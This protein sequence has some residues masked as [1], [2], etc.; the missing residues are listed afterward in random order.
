[1]ALKLITCT[2]GRT[3]T[4]PIT[5]GCWCLGLVF[6]AVALCHRLTNTITGGS[7]SNALDLIDSAHSGVGTNSIRC[8]SRT[9]SL[10]L[11]PSGTNTDGCTNAVTGCCGGH[12]LVLRAATSCQSSTSCVCKQCASFT[13]IF[14]CKVT[15]TARGTHSVISS[16]ARH[17]GECHT[18][19]AHTA[20]AAYSV[21]SL[22][23]R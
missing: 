23:A 5:G 19:L 10:V 11:R 17:I 16:M 7:C 22:C 21:L 1:M 18:F 2:R 9:D 13:F 15:H 20:V 8:G 4:L 3:G 14:G 12:T 6:S